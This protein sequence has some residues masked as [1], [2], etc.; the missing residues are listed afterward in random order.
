M[1]FSHGRSSIAEERLIRVGITGTG[2]DD[3][4]VRAGHGVAVTKTAAGVYKFEFADNP[5]TFVGI[6]GHAFRAATPSG[7][8]GYT[9]AGDTYVAPTA[10]ALG[11]IEVTVYNASDT[12]DDLEAD[13]Y[14]D[15]AFAFAAQSVIT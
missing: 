3:P 13:Q 10:G 1:N 4:T 7:V 15:V 11:Y 9:L 8:A 12:A 6:S 5:G 14:L 2:D